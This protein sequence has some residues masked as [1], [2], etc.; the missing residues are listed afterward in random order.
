MAGWSWV[1][2][3]ARSPR[4]AYIDR[5][6]KWARGSR[7]RDPGTLVV[8]GRFVKRATKR[9]PLYAVERGTIEP[10]D[11]VN[12]C[13]HRSDGPFAPGVGDR[14]ARDLL[15]AVAAGE[16]SI[17]RPRPRIDF[18]SA[19]VGQDRT[20]TLPPGTRLDGEGVQLNGRSG[21]TF[22][23]PRDRE[24]DRRPSAEGNY[25]KAARVELEMLK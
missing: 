3:E 25:C 14:D 12:W 19:A 9:S 6:P 5:Q 17:R 18:V 8:V 22:A 21:G 11:P 15:G 4:A 23:A 10:V 7:T 16:N 1:A 2:S 13:T 20:H 24:P